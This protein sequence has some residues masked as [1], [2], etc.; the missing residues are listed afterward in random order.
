MP[1]RRIKGKKLPEHNI[2]DVFV[3][4]YYLEYLIDEKEHH[5]NYIVMRLVTIIEQFCRNIV[6]YKLKDSKHVLSDKIELDV[7]F[8][9]ELIHT[10]S[11]GKRMITKEEILSASDSFQNTRAIDVTMHRYDIK[12]FDG[13][14]RKDYDELFELRN[15]LV[16]TVKKLPS[17]KI[18]KYYDLTE[19]LMKNILEKDNYILMFFDLKIRALRKL[20]KRNK[21]K[22]CYN[23]VNAYFKNAAKQ[24]SPYAELYTDWGETFLLF[25][26]HREAINCF[27]EQIKRKP[28]DDNAYFWK[29]MAL[30]YLQD[31]KRAIEC[32]NK[33]INITPD[34][35]SAYYNKGLA[36][37]DYKDHKGAIKCF[38]K[39]I[40]LDHNSGYAYYAKGRSLQKL[41]DHEEAIKCFEC[42]IKVDHV[43]TFAHFKIGTSL[44][45]LGKVDR[46]RE[47]FVK[48]LIYLSDLKNMHQIHIN[49]Y[50]GMSWLGLG[51]YNMAIECFDKT[52]EMNQKHIDALLGKGKALLNSKKNLEAEKCFKKVLQ[53]EP[54]NKKAQNGKKLALERF[55][56][57]T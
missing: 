53:Y 17:F 22:E 6:S 34:D 28:D 21:M 54:E 5:K 50:A 35:A 27:D 14:T 31:Y 1:N 4:F 45:K 16:H 15:E 39:I 23:E 3:E 20:K 44:Q 40:E 26:K 11:N 12:A 49:Y 18:R 43:L 55:E 24:K 52:L 38:D 57:C 25:E 33:I 48:E 29:A 37:Q 42:A 19:E 8:I 30:E 2:F 9:D 46:S 36:L 41:E 13:L 56:K 47:Y 10:V 51:I 7:Q 32:H